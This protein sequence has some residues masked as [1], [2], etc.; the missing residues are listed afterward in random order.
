MLEERNIANRW[1]GEAIEALKKALTDNDS[2]LSENEDAP[3]PGTVAVVVEFLKDLSAKAPLVAVP[4]FSISV[5]GTIHLSW[6]VRNGVLE[7]V[8]CD[9]SMRAHVL[10]DTEDCS[11]EAEKISE[12]LLVLAA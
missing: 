8:F 3:L 9:D 2:I 5:N 1:S 11:I 12:K 6:D 4:C 10:T 7:V